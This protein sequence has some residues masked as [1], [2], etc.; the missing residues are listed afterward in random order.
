MKRVA[1]RVMTLA[2][3]LLMI[4]SIVV[5]CG[6]QSYAAYDLYYY[7]R[8]FEEYGFVAITD[9]DIS[10]SGSLTIPDTIDG[11]PVAVIA[12]RAFMFC[13]RITNISI[14]D[15]V[16][17]IGESAFEYCDGL[18]SFYIPSSVESID[19][20]VFNNCENLKRILVD[21]ENPFYYSVNNCIIDSESGTIIAGCNNSTIPTSSDITA[22]GNKAFSGCSYF[23]EILIPNNIKS[24]GSQ[25]FSFCKN[26]KSIT[27]PKNTRDISSDAFIFCS[28][29]S[30]LSV[31]VNNP[32]YYSKN[33]CIIKH[34][35][36]TL[37]LGCRD[38][39]IPSD[40]SV[41]AI[42]DSAFC[43]TEI[44]QITIPRYVTEI[45]PFAF[46][47]CENLAEIKLPSKLRKIG[48]YAFSNCSQLREV[49]IPEN[50][51]SIGNGAFDN[52]YNIRDINVLCRYANIGERAFGYYHDR[53]YN[54]LKIDDLTIHGYSDTSAENYA[55][56]N[57]FD[58]VILAHKHKPNTEIKKA[59]LSRNGLKTTTCSVCNTV[60]SKKTIYKVQTVKL[61]KTKLIYNGKVQKPTVKVTDSKGNTLK[62]NQDYTVKYKSNK[63][64]G[65][66]T[67]TVT[68]KGNYSGT[69]TL[70][71]SIIPASP[72]IKVTTGKKQANVKLGKVSS[73]DSYTVYY[74]AKKNSGF[75]KITTAKTSCSIKNLTSGKTYYFKAV[76]NRKSGGKNYTSAYSKTVS[77][78][79]K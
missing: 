45:E 72:S 30:S 12:D 8:I 31:D 39:R 36:K 65:R 21:I 50:V 34:G 13:D 46:Y 73:A 40:G 70:T 67:V 77:C 49:T 18:S 64:V 26:L 6:I 33:N 19:E 78:K 75:K 43:G 79:I 4:C 62:L 3:T 61:S 55:N 69:T 37:A 76:A 71:F 10:M 14:P 58:F 22:I 53:D 17:S 15:S 2:I 28:S 16:V 44:S 47:S 66:A 23:Q 48:A 35:S 7:Y 1:K 41:T 57:G 52:C 27:I 25:S 68:F 32:A 38:S 51:T 60:L 5:P 29:L 9:C 42:G 54:I 56:K 20:G 59:T 11:Y 63:S 74:S 24:I